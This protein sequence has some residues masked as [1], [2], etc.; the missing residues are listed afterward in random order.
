MHL[1]NVE[2]KKIIDVI[3]INV[4]TV[5]CSTSEVT[6]L[7]YVLLLR[8]YSLLGT[9]FMLNR[10]RPGRTKKKILLFKRKIRKNAS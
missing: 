4:L 3:I 9:S 8:T 6:K 7:M 10:L 5:R 1:N 2:T